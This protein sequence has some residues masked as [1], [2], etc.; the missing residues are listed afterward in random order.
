MEILTQVQKGFLSKFA[1]TDLAEEFYLSGGTALAAFYYFHRISED[2][3]FFTAKGKVDTEYVLS[4]LNSLK[5]L[6]KILEITMTKKYDRRIF[7]LVFEDNNRLKVEFTYYPFA[8]QQPSRKV[9]QIIV[10]SILDIGANKLM[11]ILD[12]FEPKD[13][14]D[15]YFIL[16]DHSL[17]DVMEAARRK[18]Q[19]A[20]TLLALQQEFLKSGK[21]SGDEVE[22]LKPLSIEKMKSFFEQRAREISTILFEKNRQARNEDLGL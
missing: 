3:D 6:L 14:I 17:T 21:I 8:R 1:Q 5:K 20:P 22:M 10:D 12:R 13:F 2:L 4:F 18:F 15:L 9:N 19:A 11:A 7:D 16:Q